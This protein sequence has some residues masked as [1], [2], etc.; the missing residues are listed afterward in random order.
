MSFT[1]LSSFK[2]VSETVPEGSC[3]MEHPGYPKVIFASL[4]S[5]APLHWKMLAAIKQRMDAGN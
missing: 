2:A 3:L 1:L 5:V 4:R